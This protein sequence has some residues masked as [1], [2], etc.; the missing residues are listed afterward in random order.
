MEVDWCTELEGSCHSNREETG[1]TH[2][3]NTEPIT[4]RP[5]QA[6]SDLSPSAAWR[7][8]GHSVMKRDFT[9]HSQ[10]TVSR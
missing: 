1:F 6:F 10:N 8:T 2:A 5:S 9:Q 4:F 3:Q 7:P